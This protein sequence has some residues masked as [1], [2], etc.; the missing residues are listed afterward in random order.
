MILTR[1]L[2]KNNKLY[3]LNKFKY[4][5]YLYIYILVYRILFFYYYVLIILGRIK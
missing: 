2:I 4:I 3:L 5:S 1:S